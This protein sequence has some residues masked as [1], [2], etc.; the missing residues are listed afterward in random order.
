MLV[1]LFIT[2]DLIP[3]LNGSKRTRMEFL[4][5]AVIHEN[6]DFILFRLKNHTLLLFNLQSMSLKN[7]FPVIGF[8]VS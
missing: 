2:V 7:K 6:P 1:R 5:Y 8:M 3:D 4:S